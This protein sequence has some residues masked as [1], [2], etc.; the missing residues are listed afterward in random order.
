[1]TMGEQ[2]Q[3]PW[4]RRTYRW[5]QTNLTEIDPIRYD[6][7]FWRDYWRRTRVQGIIVN[8]GG[9]VAYYPSEN[10][11]QYRARFLG[12]RDL[13]GE[14]IEQAHQDGLVVLAR[15][16]CSRTDERVYLEHPD[17][18]VVDAEGRPLREGPH[19]VTCINGPY[20][21]EHIP[22]IIREIATRY[23]PEGFTDNSWSGTDR[24]RICQCSNCARRFREATGLR[25]PAA[26]NWDDPAY[27]QWILWSYARRVEV[28]E[29]FNRVAREAG[30]PDCLYLGMLG[31]DPVGQGARLRDLKAICERSEII[32]LDHQA[33]S[34][35]RGF[36]GN[37]ET[38]LLLHGLLGWDKLIP[39]STAMY[40]AQA[41]RSFRLAAKPAAEA[42]MWA[43]AGWAGGIQPWWHHIGAYHEDR[44]QYRTAEALFRWHEA[45]QEY[46]VNRRPLATIGV[47][48]SQTNADFYGR[49][50][51]QE[52]VSQ[53]AQGI[54]QALVR[55]RIPFLP[56]HA[57]HIERD[58]PNLAAL[59][60]PNIGAL[61]DEQC[62]AIRRFVEAGGG[63]VATGESSL[64]DRWGDR[65]P[66]FALADL[67]GVH[68]TGTHHGTSGPADPAWDAWATHTYLRLHPELRAGVYGPRTGTEPTPAGE[69]HS[70]LQGFE[71]TDILPFGGRLEVVTLDP[72]AQA[73]VPLTYIPP[74]PIYPPETAW[75]RHPATS[76]PA[77]VLREHAGGRVAYFAADID[78][79]LA[80]DNLPD[81]ARLLANTVRWAA[82][83]RIPLRVE[84]PGLLGCHPYRQDRRCIVHLLNLTYAE[85]MRP[86]IEEALPTG[87]YTIWLQLPAGVAGRA[88]RL[89]VAE[90]EVPVTV[91]DGWARLEVPGILEHEVL[92][93][94]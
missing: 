39:E 31:G 13:F 64:Y 12:D 71:E 21:E 40:Q 86:P 10:R 91:E 35:Q 59:V 24:S 82:R 55:A 43:I 50:T 49:D 92:V 74:F 79:C 41:G 22:T 44:R 34:P 72:A 70:V 67:F 63:L 75:M 60:L 36:H 77:L 90:R 19:Y 45:N 69:R 33:R 58:A 17:W 42:R 61:T 65:R 6:A 25:L 23:H 38:G 29:L 28:W 32:M 66:D 37:A 81:H 48:W 88:A 78:R 85:T 57:D 4:Y 83:E 3:A 73:T 26:K 52:R 1:V 53:P 51:A 18:F 94:T 87:P 16:D 84:G 89:L 54:A 30:G 14:I 20:Y 62:Q 2:G 27:R 15:M 80:R 93:I 56:V 11:L 46:L 7:A 76:L 9:I 8:A 5:G 68:A 47:V